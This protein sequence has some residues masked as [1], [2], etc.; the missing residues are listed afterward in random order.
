[1]SLQ[2]TQE[3]ADRWNAHLKSSKRLVEGDRKRRT[4]SWKIDKARQMIKVGES[5]TQIV[6]QVHISSER[7]DRIKR[8][9]VEEG[10]L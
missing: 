9:M 7:V 1:M 5:K 10:T 4:P 2:L 3:E 8:E 6:K